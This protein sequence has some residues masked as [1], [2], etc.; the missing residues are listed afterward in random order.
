MIKV[1]GSYMSKID[2]SELIQNIF[3]RV[4]ANNK[5]RAG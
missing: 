1:S 4:R 3:H 2:A 5:S